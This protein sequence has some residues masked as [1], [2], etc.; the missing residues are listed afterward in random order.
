MKYDAK[1]IQQAVTEA[2]AH[3]QQFASHDDGGTCNFD[4]CI[5]YVPGMRTATAKQIQ[6]T[7]LTDSSWHGRS[8][9]IGGT[10]G[11]GARRTKMAEAQRDFLKANYPDINIGMYYQMD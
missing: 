9:H 11:Q 2:I 6:N 4:A 10:L 1:R 7:F 8:L 3:A 5:L